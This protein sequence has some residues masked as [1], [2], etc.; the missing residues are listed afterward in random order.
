ME[1]I[2]SDLRLNDFKVSTESIFE[3]EKISLIN[4]HINRNIRAT[5]ALIEMSKPFIKIEKVYRIP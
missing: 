3:K 4:G 5:L 2:Q 1:K